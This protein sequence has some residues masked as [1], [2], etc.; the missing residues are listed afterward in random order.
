MPATSCCPSCCCC[1]RLCFTFSSAG[2]QG[3]DWPLRCNRPA[4]S[5]PSANTS[6]LL[7]P[8]WPLHG[9]IFLPLNPAHA[10][11]P[12]C[13]P[14]NMS[15]ST[16][17]QPH[18][19]SSLHQPTTPPKPTQ[20]CTAAHLSSCLPELGQA[21]QVSEQDACH[22]CHG[23][24]AVV[25]LTLTVPLQLVLVGGA[26]AQGVKACADAD[27]CVLSLAQLLEGSLNTSLM[28][29]TAGWWPSCCNPSCPKMNLRKL[30]LTE[31]DCHCQQAMLAVCN[32][33]GNR[34]KQQTVVTGC[35][36]TAW[37]AVSCYPP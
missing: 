14:D 28:V 7:S 27:I 24:A 15:Q 30:C 4:A 36:T 1:C 16:A 25:Q 20:P 3:T 10:Q 29:P 23:P 22:C 8:A 31:A 13:W 5:D 35:A 9:S 19:A 2:D 32:Q 17:L 33:L 26:Q 37:L 21:N 18:P 6:P 34:L 11:L 12:L